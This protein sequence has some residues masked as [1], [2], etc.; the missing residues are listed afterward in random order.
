MHLYKKQYYE[1]LSIQVIYVVK[2]GQCWWKHVFRIGRHVTEATGW[3][4]EHTH[5]T[6]GVINELTK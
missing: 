1:L 6:D 3:L 5:Q 4:R 2:P